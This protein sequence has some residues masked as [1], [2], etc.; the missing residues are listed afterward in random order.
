[1]TR[2]VKSKREY[3]CVKCNSSYLRWEGICRNCGEGNTLQEIILVPTTP[4]PRED[5]EQRKLRRRAKTSER[6]IAKRMV[7]ADGADPAFA[8]IASSTGRIGHITG[9]RVDAVSRNYVTENKN[10]KVPSWMIDAW[11]LI[12]QRGNHFSKNVLLHVEPPNMPKEYPIDGTT[13][14]LDTMAIITQTRHEE[15]IKQERLL[16]ELENAIFS[17]DKKYKSL[18][19]LVL[20]LQRR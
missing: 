17:D 10:R 16:A 13:M 5:I 11:V 8:K 1:M 12:N 19:E 7:A 18:Q 4:R 15:L 14:K 2:M 9:I 3:R 6:N 20:A